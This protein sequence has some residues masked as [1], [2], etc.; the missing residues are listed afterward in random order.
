MYLAGEGW[1]VRCCRERSRL[2]HVLVPPHDRATREAHPRAALATRKV[3]P[4]PEVRLASLR[5]ALPVI[6]SQLDAARVVEAQRLRMKHWNEDPHPEDA[7][8]DSYVLEDQLLHVLPKI[9]RGGFVL[10]LWSTLEAC[11]KDLALFASDRTRIALPERHFDHGGFIKAAELA[12]ER[13]LGVPAFANIAEK[14]QLVRLAEIRAALV[15]HNGEISRLPQ[16][17]R[18]GGPLALEAEGL[19]A[20]KDLRHEYFV[21]MRAFLETRLELVDSHLRALRGRVERLAYG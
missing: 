10:A 16:D 4:S 11:T 12:F 5:A 6:E 9:I 15:H 14:S 21:P 2:Q 18:A 3:F 20:E 7:A 8:I 17:L 19:Y 1:A 13:H